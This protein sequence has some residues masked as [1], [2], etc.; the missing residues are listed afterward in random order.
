MRPAVVVILHPVGEPL[1][2]LLERVEAG[3]AEELLLERLPEPLDLS[4]R[5]GMVR[6]AADMV[7]VVAA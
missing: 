1:A 6:R 2:R 7:H 5:H 4:K 3:A